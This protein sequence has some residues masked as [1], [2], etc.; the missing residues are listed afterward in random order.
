VLTPCLS[1]PL[2]FQAFELWGFG[3]EVLHRGCHGVVARL[4]VDQT[5]H[6]EHHSTV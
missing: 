2:G 3:G 6:L 1:P 5:M 4:L